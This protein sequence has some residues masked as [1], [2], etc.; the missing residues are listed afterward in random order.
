[1]G[2]F[3]YVRM[4][5]GISSAPAVFQAIMNELLKGLPGVVCYLDDV[6]ITGASHTECL[7]RVEAV[8]QV[9]RDH[10]VKVRKEK[11]KFFLNSVKYLGHIIDENGV[12]PC[13]EKVEAI[14]EAPTPKNISELK[15][16]LGMI[17][18]Y[19]KFMPNMS[20]RLKPLY[21]L[22]QKDKKWVWSAK[23]EKAFAESK[24]LL[25]QASVL[26]FYD[27]KKPLGLVCD[28]SP[29]GNA[30]QHTKTP[31][32]HPASNG[33]AERLV[34]TVKRSFIKQLRD[35]QNT[36]ATR[37]MQHRVDQFLFTYRNTPCSTTGKTPAELFL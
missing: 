12:H 28:A 23:E 30:V 31:P 20:S 26:T 15:A 34:Q 24:S 37:T 19:S 32:Y 9:F 33:T 4:P 21:A 27:P 7:A 5:Y 10:G 14:R 25:T 36:G 1:M 8:L 3:Q 29:Y 22:L 18:F 13:V 35:E 17:T 11:C 6:L 2:L 16:Y